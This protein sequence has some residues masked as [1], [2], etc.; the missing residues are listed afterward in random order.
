MT[1]EAIPG[2]G[3]ETRESRISID[4]SF[5]MVQSWLRTIYL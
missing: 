2:T 1:V 3:T 5:T 4:M